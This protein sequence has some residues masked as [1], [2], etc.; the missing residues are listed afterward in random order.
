MKHF[1]RNYHVVALMIALIFAQGLKAGNEIV[2]RQGQTGNL[3]VN[4]STYNHLQVTNTLSALQ[5]FDVKTGKGEF[6]RL[7]AQSYAG[8]DTYGSPELP[9]LR[10][11]IEIPQGAEPVVKVIGY[12]VN[13][14]NLSDYGIRPLF[15]AQ[16]PVSKSETNPELVYNASAYLQ[17]SFTGRELAAVDVLGML[18]GARLGRLNI[19]P[20]Q[21][22][23]VTNTIRV[24]NNL[25]IDVTF[26]NANISLTKSEKR[27][28]DSPY[29][30]SVYNRLINYQQ[31]DNMRDTMSKFPIK[32]V[33]VSPQ[34]FQSALQPFIA[35]KKKKGFTVVEAYTNNPAVGTTTTSIKNYLHGLYTAATP[36]NPA[37]SFVLFVGD[38]AQIP[39]FS[40]NDG[41]VSDLYYC[42]YSGDY[43]PEVYY[44]R[45]SA[46]TVAQLQPQIDKTLEYEQYLMPDPSFLN[47]VVMV[48]GA[49][50]SHQMTWGNGQ[51][52]YGT[53]LYFNAAH[54]LTSHTYLQPEPSGGNYSGQIHS[55]VSNGVGFAN[56]TAHGSPDGWYD[57]SFTI[58]DIP[59][60]QNAHKY[61]LMVGNCC[62]TSTYNED[63]FGE[64]LLRASN[65]GALG[66]IG[67]SNSSYWDED[68]WWG[69]GVGAITANP[70]YATTTL[71]AYDRTF[72]DH[73]EPYDEWYSS[74]DQMVFAGNLAVT[75]S[76][77]GMKQYYWE[78]YCLMGDP[79]L[80][81]YFSVPPAMNVTYSQLMP[82][83]S[84][85]FTVN[86]EPYAYVA[87]SKDGV[88]YGAAEADAM[89]VAVVPLTP[90]TVPG[91]ADVVVTK[92]NRQPYI[93]TVV[94]ASPDGPYVLFNSYEIDDSNGNNNQIA[95]FGENIL[96]DITLQNVGN[97]NATN[98]TSTIS[99]DDEF[100]TVTD[101]TELIP[102]IQSQTSITANAAFAA[103]LD[104]Y[105][106]DEHVAH[107]T[108]TSTC[109]TNTW[110]SDFSLVLYAPELA[111]GQFTIDDAIGGNGNGRI[112]PGETVNIIIP[113][114]NNGHCFAVNTV[115]T[116]ISTGSDVTV[117][118]SS[119]NLGTIA[120][121]ASINAVFSVTISP[122]AEV[123]SIITL[124]YIS[125]SG[126][127]TTITDLYPS[128]G[129]L[130]ED[131]ETGN[132]NK[133]AWQMGGNAGWTITTSA[134]QQGSYSAQSGVIDDDQTSELYLEANVLVNDTISFYRKVSSEGGYDYLKF[135]VDGQALG[136]WDGT[137]SWGKV[138][139]PITA[140][141]HTFKWSYEKDYS[142]SSG[143]DAAMVD[144]I[145]FPSFS[146]GGS[147]TLS[148][149]A[150][151]LPSSI[152]L[153]N[154]TQLYSF[155]SGGSGSYAF[156]WTPSTGLSDTTIFNPIANPIVTTTYTARIDNLLAFA[157]S[158]VTITVEP[159]PE[160]PVITQV[161]DV[162]E[163]SAST[164]NQWYSS[165]GIII[166]ATGP[167]YTPEYTDSYYVIVTSPLGCESLS[168][169]SI[170]FVYTNLTEIQ[171]QL[172]VY[173]NPFK[174][175]VIVVCKLANETKA[176]LA[177]YNA[178]GKEM[179]I[180]Y[181][182]SS[183]P[184][185][186]HIVDV[187]FQDFPVGVYYCKLF[188]GD[189]VIVT[190]LIHTR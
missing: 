27:R 186:Q 184:A 35:W 12:T 142:T 49:D 182:W 14:Y 75:E 25:V 138:S 60:L 21:Y 139:Y 161:G 13:E 133:F 155:G 63:C 100:L 149:S 187:Q 113:T 163:S 132:F 82:L 176:K 86:A 175:K 188:T 30:R 51:I 168:S 190:K 26:K 4:E 122:D 56:Y 22:N 69:V 158:Q 153:G 123:G 173:P 45:F 180:L 91:T 3:T 156:S 140:G 48:A 89:G 99:T 125:T 65:K 167:T 43:L 104:A 118:T 76:S 61:P 31:T 148:V 46:T 80:M 178:M 73:G 42:E 164:G 131:F 68:Y 127:Y 120:A 64:E 97:S 50:A 130:V 66:Y 144:Y 170:Y 114:I 94:V 39:A 102:N 150:V 128:V 9:V 95:D 169:N 159:L 101:S 112:D 146:T 124:H 11:L 18:R 189:K 152:C 20:V 44:G 183:L 47:E 77:S 96:F 115:G 58:S 84:N 59:N 103:T 33:I 119:V 57:P 78:I 160:T 62:Q 34:M 151:A 154:Q 2:F 53:C 87:I 72:H 136:S 88:L 1:L 10:K 40:C 137:V 117:N 181:N 41:H 106:P 5:Y 19:S 121:G 92:Q 90:I 172:G 71:G 157:T 17:N 36:T 15:P 129:Q 110:S 32:Y 16:P 185:G 67:G 171:P 70:T 23:P 83:S 179:S 174:D 28:Y 135:Y 24:Y 126:L 147:G 93:G 166:G 85:S 165:T 6:T 52:N 134:V 98:V 55:D 54:G 108:I 141:Q 143:S 29:F 79:S 38:V 74:M 145:V 116:L 7:Q 177:L 105:V 109:D 81:V 8:S 162:L 37:P 107:F 111:A